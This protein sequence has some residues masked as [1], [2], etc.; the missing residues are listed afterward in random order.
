MPRRLGPM[1]AWRIWNVRAIDTESR[2]VLDH[3]TLAIE[4]GRI[5]EV[6]AAHGEAPEGAYDGR[7][8][9]VIPAL[10]DC[11]T[12]LISDTSRS[13]GFGP[14]APL[15]GED[16]RPRELGCLLLARSCRALLASGVTTI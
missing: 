16:P 4:D 11:H 1:D 2:S 3:A 7:G 6:A 5:T 12:H 15:K 9:S 8:R 10:I 14:P 13:P